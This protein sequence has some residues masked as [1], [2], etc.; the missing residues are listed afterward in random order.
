MPTFGPAYDEGLDKKRI[1]TQMGVILDFMLSI[2]EFR[3]GGKILGG[4]WRTLAEIRQATGFPE[5][6]V[7]AQ[8][9]HLRKRRFG[10]YI[11]EKRRQEPDGGTW[12]YR[13]RISEPPQAKQAEFGFGLEQKAL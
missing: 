4:G 9:R 11:V 7:S 13:V 5:A 10:A 2:M 1:I 8:L 12:E 3:T 6:S